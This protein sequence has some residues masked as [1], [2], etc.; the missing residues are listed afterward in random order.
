[1]GLKSLKLLMSVITC[2]VLPYDYW[3]TL[4]YGFIVFPHILL[5]TP[6]MKGSDHS[7]LG[8]F[9]SEE[10]VASNLRG[11]KQSLL[12]DKGQVCYKTVSPSNSKSFSCNT[13]LLQMQYLPCQ[14]GSP[15]PPHGT[16]ETKGTNANMMP[17]AVLWKIKSF[18]PDSVIP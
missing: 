7:S 16:L 8:P 1:M 14:L 4:L 15:P 9:L 6:R 11:M 18:V 3:E 10:S 2:D 17:F 12:Q 13:D 5:G